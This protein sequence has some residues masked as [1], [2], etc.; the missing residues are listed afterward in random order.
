MFVRVIAL[1]L[2]VATTCGLLA[3]S[4]PVRVVFHEPKTEAVAAILPV[5][6]RQRIQ[7]T[8]TGAMA[9]GLTVDG[10]NLSCGAGAI[11][12]NFKI[13]GQLV[14]PNVAVNA[15]KPLPADR[16]GK[17]RP[18][19]Q[20]SFDANGVRITQMLEVIPSKSTPGSTKRA[21]DNCLI[22]Y[23][24][25]NT[26]KTTR[27][28]TTR[29]RIDTM[30]GSNDGALFA[31]P[32]RPNEILNGVELS[33]KTLP[34]YVQILETPNLKAP[35]F[36]GHFT[37]K[38]PGNRIGPN[39]FLCTIHGGDNGWDAAA[40]AA[41]GDTDCVLYWPTSELKP[42]ET[43]EM[44]YA[45]GQGI[46]SL[47]EGEGRIKVSLGGNFEP[48]R[49]FHI[50]AFVEAPFPGQSVSIELPE[51]MTLVDGDATQPAAPATENSDVAALLWRGRVD[52]TGDFPIRIRSSNGAIETRTVSVQN[53][54]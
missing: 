41:N 1:G 12:T 32:T 10:K 48:G 31:A 34:E 40:V 33:G 45:Y 53:G 7:Y 29:V 36:H 4:G 43:V 2:V 13:D 6:G 39:R 23:I 8:N 35:G 30:C 15:V 38:L 37:L 50:H 27:T 28:V 44:A 49:L 20:S 5:D 25:E 51:G 21:L 54:E 26:G 11:R 19:A 17:P 9:F 3:Q 24:F 14:H 18:G 46:A 22:R 16:N 42:G 52:R 47:P